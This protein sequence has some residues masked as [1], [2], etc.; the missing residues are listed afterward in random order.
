MTIH[1]QVTELEGIKF[2]DI[3]NG[4]EQV[5]SAALLADMKVLNRKVASK[6]LVGGQH[7]VMMT[8]LIL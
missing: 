8:S 6:Q 3:E 5:L 2:Q 4:L 1:F 7:I